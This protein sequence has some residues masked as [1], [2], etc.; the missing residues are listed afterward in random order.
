MTVTPTSTSLIQQP[1]THSFYDNQF[2][3]LQPLLWSEYGQY[4]PYDERRLFSAVNEVSVIG[5]KRSVT[6]VSTICEIHLLVS[7]FLFSFGSFYVVFRLATT[8]CLSF[9]NNIPYQILSVQ[10][11]FHFRSAVRAIAFSAIKSRHYWDLL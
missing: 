9:I 11:T 2:S 5:R 1:G 3:K 4:F 7:S 8:N 6:F 10:K